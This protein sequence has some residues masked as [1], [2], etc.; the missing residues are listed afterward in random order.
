MLTPGADSSHW[1]DF[2]SSHTSVGAHGCVPKGLHS[3][4]SKLRLMGERKQEALSRGGGGEHSRQK[5]GVWGYRREE[6][7]KCICREELYRVC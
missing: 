3:D 2:S 7:T 6:M 1:G 5:A 4:C